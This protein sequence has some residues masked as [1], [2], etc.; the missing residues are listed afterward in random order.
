MAG[1]DETRAASGEKPRLLDYLD[2]SV[3]SFGL[4]GFTLCHIRHSP[5]R[6]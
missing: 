5:F 2:I 3:Y 6:C 1:V 4:R